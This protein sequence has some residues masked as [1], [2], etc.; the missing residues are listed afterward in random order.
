MS[1][2][3]YSRNERLADGAVHVIGLALAIAAVMWL[4]AGLPGD[5][6]AGLW[7]SLVV[8]S[9]AL[10]IMLGASG[11]YHILADTGLRPVLRR[12]DHAAIYVKIAGTF[13]PLAALLGTAFGYVTL[14]AVW[15]LALI[16]AGAKLMTGRGKMHTGFWPYLVLGW[17]GLALFIPLIPRLPS[18][19]LGLILAGGLLYTA[20]ILFYAWEKLR[21]STAI[22]HGFVMVASGCFFAA[23]AAALQMI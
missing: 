16:G 5:T 18:L 6:T 7:V 3:P 1:Y 11:A 8:Y 23:I 21:F 13:T 19:S 2:P 22:W 15:T 9:A 12:V 4:F 10:L 20:G 17:L 14:L